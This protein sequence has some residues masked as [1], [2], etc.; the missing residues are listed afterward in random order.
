M[1]IGWFQRHR[2]AKNAH[3]ALVLT[4]LALVQS[5]QEARQ[6]RE[7]AEQWE[8]AARRIAVDLVNV[9]TPEA[10]TADAVAVAYWREQLEATLVTLAAH[11]E[12]HEGDAA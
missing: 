3:T 10:G 11:L 2:N 9:T 8:S 4:T 1:V 5:R 6:A 12:T 7:D